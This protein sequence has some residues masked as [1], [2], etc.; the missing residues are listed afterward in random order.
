MCL[1]SK[2]SAQLTHHHLAILSG[3]P[4]AKLPSLVGIDWLSNI[5]SPLGTLGGSTRSSTKSTLLGKLL[6]N[7]SLQDHSSWGSTSI[8]PKCG[9]LEIATMDPSFITVSF[10]F[11][12][13]TSFAA[14]RIK[15]WCWCLWWL[16]VLFKL[17]YSWQAMV[18]NTCPFLPAVLTEGCQY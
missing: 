12:V 7:N 9:L 3:N 6:G 2:S 15:P 16:G 4:Q 8:A 1:N 11:W 5:L 13:L 10:S 18:F 14:I 17:Q